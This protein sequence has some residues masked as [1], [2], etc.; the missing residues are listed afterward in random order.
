MATATNDQ[1]PPLLALPVELVGRIVHSLTPESLLMLRL[2][3]KVLEH[4][5]HDLFAKKF[6]SDG[7]AASTMSLVGYS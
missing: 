2:T 5:T 6:L 7:T 3:C 4:S 1:T